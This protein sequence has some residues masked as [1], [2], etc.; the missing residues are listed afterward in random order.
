[1]TMPISG[2]QTVKILEKQGFVVSRQKGSHVVL[3][4]VSSEGK[5]TT[6]VPL[7]KEMRKGTLR[8]VAKQAGIDT[9]LFGL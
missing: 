5:Q 3:V 9:K 4:K 2:K 6:V 8:G 7:H 1:M